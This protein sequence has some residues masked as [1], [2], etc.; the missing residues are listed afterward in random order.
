MNRIRFSAF[1]FTEAEL[2]EYWLRCL[3]FKPKYFYGYVSML[4]AFARFVKESGKDGSVLGLKAVITTSEV[5]TDA[6]RSLIGE[7]FGVP[8]QNEYGCGEVGPIAYECEAGSMHI[9]SENVLV[10]LLGESG[11]PVAEGEEGEIVVT[12]LNN[13][14]M[15]LLRYRIRDFAVRLSECECSRGFPVL[16]SVR[17]RA[18]DTITAPS[19][20]SYHGEF[21]MYL[22]EDLR[23]AGSRFERFRVIQTG[24]NALEVEIQTR[25]L[26]DA[27]LI[28]TVRES[29]M[30]ELSNMQIDVRLVHEVELSGSGKH[31]L[32]EN[33]TGSRD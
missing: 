1:G 18:Y 9:M 22:F 6:Q 17:G 10:E 4:E 7:S 8:V 27:A 25:D 11:D 30:R 14:A 29:L 5:L 28:A 15:P 19:G 23:D 32:V 20:R 26:Q 31:R 2:E 13:V 33:R 16:G 3:R 12:D 21:F 24:S